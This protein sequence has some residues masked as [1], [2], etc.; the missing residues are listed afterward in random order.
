MNTPRATSNTM[1]DHMVAEIKGSFVTGSV[2][3]PITPIKPITAAS[4]IIPV[5]ADLPVH[6]AVNNM[7]KKNGIGTPNSVPI[8]FTK[9]I[10]VSVPFV[11]PY[12][13]KLSTSP[14]P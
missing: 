2:K 8:W 14:L 1:N 5:G 13:V 12:D 10:S 11:A 9:L 6:N 7:T 3:Y 4:A